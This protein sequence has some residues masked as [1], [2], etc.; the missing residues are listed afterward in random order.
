MEYDWQQKA[1]LQLEEMVDKIN[2]TQHQRG[3]S[4]YIYGIGVANVEQGQGTYLDIV[5]PFTEGDY[6]DITADIC[7]D[8]EELAEH[9]KGLHGEPD[10][11]TPTGTEEQDPEEE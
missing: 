2:A 9:V 7:Y 8:V 1:R 11:Q 4:F 6:A 5:Q 10:E 3:S